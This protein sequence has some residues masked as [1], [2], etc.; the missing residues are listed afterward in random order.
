LLKLPAARRAELWAAVVE[1]A[2][3]AEARMERQQQERNRATKKKQ[4]H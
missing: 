3:A 4:E 2:K 1:A